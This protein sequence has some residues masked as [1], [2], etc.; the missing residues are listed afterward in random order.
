M[1]AAVDGFG[2]RREHEAD[3]AVGDLPPARE[4]F[5][6]SGHE[7]D[8]ARLAGLRAAL[9]GAPHVDARRVAFEPQA[10]PRKR[11]DL[12]DPH[13][14]IDG[15]AEDRALLL[16]ERELE[17]SVD[18]AALQVSPGVFDPLALRKLDESS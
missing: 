8:R 13:A 12:A 2:R 7:R 1:L 15:D 18:F 9:P 16:R 3:L 17:D 6:R 5:A 11:G 14:L 10:L 4:R